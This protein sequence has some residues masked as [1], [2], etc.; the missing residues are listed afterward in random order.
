MSS[1][2]SYSTII[3]IIDKNHEWFMEVVDPIHKEVV[4]GYYNILK[5]EIWRSG[6]DDSQPKVKEE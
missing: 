3:E 5:L 4:E 2:T 1:D 6:F